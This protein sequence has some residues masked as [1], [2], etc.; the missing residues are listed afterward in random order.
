M[1]QTK[2]N[3]P[4]KA[5]IQVVS[6]LNT[7]LADCLD[8][9]TQAKQAH[10]NVKGPSFHAL[11]LL[12]DEVA[13]DIEA[14]SD[15]IAE[16]LVQLGGTARGTAREVAASSSLAEYPHEIT[17]GDEHLNVL[18]DALA[19]FGALVREGIT[20]CSTFSMHSRVSR[21][22]P[23]LYRRAK[24]AS[25]AGAGRPTLKSLVSPSHLTATR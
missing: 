14:Y 1:Q 21:R 19:A 10:W 2:N 22:A 16:R 11:H 24:P 6:Y 3:I 17:K 18:A 13:E 9:G 23:Y 5:R 8:L 7:R 20:D 15:L 4:L 12:F 25:E